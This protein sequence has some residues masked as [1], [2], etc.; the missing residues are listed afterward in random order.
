M[1]QDTRFGIYVNQKQMKSLEKLLTLAVSLKVA[2]GNIKYI[3]DHRYMFQYICEV[4]F[5]C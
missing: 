2:V 5:S 4:Y 1:T 3:F